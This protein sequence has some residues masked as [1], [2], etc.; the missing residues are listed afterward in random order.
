MK[1]STEQLVATFDTFKKE[2]ATALDAVGDQLANGRYVEAA[3]A[4]NTLTERVAKTS[5]A[6]RAILIRTGYIK[7]DS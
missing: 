1:V 3:D 6:M 5:V 4:M 2:T 7:A